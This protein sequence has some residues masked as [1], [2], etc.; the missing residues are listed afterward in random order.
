MCGSHATTRSAS[1]GGWGRGT[2]PAQ[3]WIEDTVTTFLPRSLNVSA[4]HTAAPQ[5][6]RGVLSSQRADT[7]AHGVGGPAQVHEQNLV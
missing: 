2:A 1:P 7:Q 4:I 5:E 3:L 6:R